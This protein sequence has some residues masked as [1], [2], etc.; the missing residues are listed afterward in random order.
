MN[1]FAVSGKTV[2]YRKIDGSANSL[3]AGKFSRGA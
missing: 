3:S 1:S 2:S